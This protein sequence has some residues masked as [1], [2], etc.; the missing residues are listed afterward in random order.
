MCVMRV[1]IFIGGVCL[2]GKDSTSSPPPLM[3]MELNQ[4]LVISFSESEETVFS[5]YHYAV[6]YCNL[7][8]FPLNQIL[9]NIAN[10]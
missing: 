7:F 5:V 4:Q 10:Y 1:F 3:R 9:C 8:L 2:Q 6:L